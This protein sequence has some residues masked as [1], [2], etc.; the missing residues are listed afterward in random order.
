MALTAEQ[1]TEII[2]TVNGTDFRQP[3]HVEQGDIMWY[4]GGKDNVKNG[5]SLKMV[6]NSSDKWEEYTDQIHGL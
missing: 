6:Y 1:K 2:N 4:P 5:N 3:P